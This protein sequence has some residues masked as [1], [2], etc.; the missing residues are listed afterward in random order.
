MSEKP[1]MSIEKCIIYI[2]KMYTVVKNLLLNMARGGKIKGQLNENFFERLHMY[3]S[4]ID[5]LTRKYKGAMGQNL[6]GRLKGGLNM[7]TVEKLKGHLNENFSLEQWYMCKGDVDN[8]T[9]KYKGAMGQKLKGG[10][11]ENL[12][13]CNYRVRMFLTWTRVILVIKNGAQQFQIKGKRSRFNKVPVVGILF[14]CG[15]CPTQDPKKGENLK[16]T[17]AVF[18]KHD[19]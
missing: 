17:L 15:E 10:F 8:I 9:R 2:G 11:N 7:S 5:N 14:V 13:S 16:R 3:K 19:D 4:V 18:I 12:A 1:M 6:K